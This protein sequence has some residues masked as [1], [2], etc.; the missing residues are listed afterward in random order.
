VKCKICG[1][2]P[3]IKFI[4]AGKIFLWKIPEGISS[5]WVSRE[6]FSLGTDYKTNRD[7][8]EIKCSCGYI[9]YEEIRR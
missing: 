1:K 3:S 5:E 2:E 9:Y 4:P 8:R 6:E 7:L